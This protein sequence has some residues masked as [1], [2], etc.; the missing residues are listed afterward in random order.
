MKKFSETQ[1]QF[2]NGDLID[3][4]DLELYINGKLEVKIACLGASNDDDAK[5]WF[6]N[7]DLLEIAEYQI[8]LWQRF[9]DSKK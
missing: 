2:S 3:S 6:N 7:D 5:S 1:C 8:E 9:I 4:T